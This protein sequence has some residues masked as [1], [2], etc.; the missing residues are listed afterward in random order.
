MC[1]CGHFG[2]RGLD[3]NLS[4]VALHETGN[5]THPAKNGNVHKTLSQKDRRLLLGLLTLSRCSE[6]RALRPL[7]RERLNAARQSG[8]GDVGSEFGDSASGPRTTRG[9]CS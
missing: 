8:T 9:S 2:H 7:C 1:V 3:L 4:F 6:L 5:S